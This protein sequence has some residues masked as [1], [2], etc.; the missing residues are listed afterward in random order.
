VKYVIE[1]S[2][3][4]EIRNESWARAFWAV[5]HVVVNALHVLHVKL[6]N[7]LSIFTKKSKKDVDAKVAL[8]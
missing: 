1:R 4:A 6:H 7:F 2:K 5:G 8:Q 3:I